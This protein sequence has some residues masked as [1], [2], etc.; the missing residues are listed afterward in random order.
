MAVKHSMSRIISGSCKYKCTGA[1][2]KNSCQVQ[3]MLHYL[4]QLQ[5]QVQKVQVQVQV[6]QL[7]TNVR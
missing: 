5:V 4:R 7:R 2:V 1:A 6:Q 3:H